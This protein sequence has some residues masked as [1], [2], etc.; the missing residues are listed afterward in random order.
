MGNAISILNQVNNMR[1]LAMVFKKKHPE[2]PMDLSKFETTTD[3]KEVVRLFKEA[4]AIFKMKFEVDM[5]DS[6]IV[7]KFVKIID[8]TDD[9]ELLEYIVR[10]TTANIGDR[11]LENK[12]MPESVLREYAEIQMEDEIDVVWYRVGILDNPNTPKDLIKKLIDEYAEAIKENP[13]SEDWEYFANAVNEKIDGMP[14]ELIAYYLWKTS[15]IISLYGLRYDNFWDE[16]LDWEENKPIFEE[17]IKKAPEEYGCLF[18]TF[19]EWTTE[20]IAK[21]ALHEEPNVRAG[22]IMHK[23]TD[24]SVIQQLTK[25]EDE[26][27][28]AMAEIQLEI[29]TDKKEE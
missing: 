8:E 24:I 28:V 10:N 5:Y 21:L 1:A 17:L 22:V 18:V 19:G 9:P 7:K 27:V 25:D 2:F 14:L 4:V 15:F 6:E 11:A 13:D 20:E 26:D 12:Y 16:E 29:L 23:N 3:T